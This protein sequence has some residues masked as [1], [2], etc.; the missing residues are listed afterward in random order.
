MSLGWRVEEKSGVHCPHSLS[1]GLVAVA[2]SP[3]PP[4]EPSPGGSSFSPR[5][6]QL[7]RR[8]RLAA[9]AS[10]WPACLQLGSSPFTPPTFIS[11]WKAPPAP[12]GTLT[13]AAASVGG[14]RKRVHGPRTAVTTNSPR[15]QP[16][17][18]RFAPEAQETS[19][20]SGEV[21]GPERWRLTTMLGGA[22]G[23]RMFPHKENSTIQGISGMR[24]KDLL[25]S[26][27]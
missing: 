8:E 1:V 25:R 6:V 27:S 16:R 12:A 9:A 15:S 2:G 7:R 13:G 21:K 4:P 20:F 24:W 5:A 11:P 19:E 3:S 22:L 17:F 23:I 26:V 18:S 14:M 10:P